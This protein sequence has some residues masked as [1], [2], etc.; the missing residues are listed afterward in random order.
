[1]K[2]PNIKKTLKNWRPIR[3][4][5]KRLSKQ[6]NKQVLLTEFGYRNVPYAGR[7]PWTHDKGDATIDNKAQQNLYSAFFQTFWDREWIAGGFAWKWFSKPE[8]ERPTSFSVQGK[9]AIKE[10]KYWYSMN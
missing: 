1:M 2:T 7:R 9:P 5:L 8:K 10:L 3:K 6:T 4:Q